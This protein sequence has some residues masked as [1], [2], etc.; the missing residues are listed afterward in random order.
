V[1]GALACHLPET[2]EVDAA[3]R[4]ALLRLV[5]RLLLES[6]PGRVGCLGIEEED[7]GDGGSEDEVGKHGDTGAGAEMVTEG[8]TAHGSTMPCAH[9]LPEGSPAIG[10]TIAAM[11]TASARASEADKEIFEVHTAVVLPHI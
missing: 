9:A 6:I 5:A 7:Q 2:K 3:E 10:N 4:S 11:A 1:K 8:G